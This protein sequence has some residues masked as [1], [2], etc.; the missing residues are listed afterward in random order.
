MSKNN[1]IRILE[2]RI[3]YIVSSVIATVAIIFAFL[4]LIIS[5]EGSSLIFIILRNETVF[6]VVL[7][8]EIIILFCGYRLAYKYF[9]KIEDLE[10]ITGIEDFLK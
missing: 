3:N 8:L 5:F 4:G 9:R 10:G 2:R 6:T 7:L 1:K